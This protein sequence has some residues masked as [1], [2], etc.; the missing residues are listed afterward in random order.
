MAKR[1]IML[2][3]EDDVKDQK[4][5]DQKIEEEPIT[6]KFKKLINEYKNNIRINQENK[7]LESEIDREFLKRI[8]F[9]PWA[10]VP[11]PRS[12][13]EYDKMMNDNKNYSEKLENWLKKED[14][15]PSWKTYSHADNLIIKRNQEIK[16]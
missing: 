14:K 16:R 15:Y 8:G 5:K 12:W 3:E 10:S 2:D 7:Y 9:V 11:E 4:I 1:E 6:E 13:E